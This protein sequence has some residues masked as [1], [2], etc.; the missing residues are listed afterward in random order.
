VVR[1]CA[2]HSGTDDKGGSYTEHWCASAV[3]IRQ[4]WILTAAHVVH[5]AEKGTITTDDDAKHTLIKIIV[6]KDYVAGNVGWHDIAL[7]RTEKPVALEF[8][9]KLYRASDELNKACTFAGWGLAGTF[10]SGGTLNDHKRRAGHNRIEGAADAVLFCS[11]TR[12]A[13]KFP[14]EFMITPGDSGGGMFIGNELAGINSFLMAADGKPNGTYTDETAFTRVSMYADW[15]ESQITQHELAMQARA[16][17]GT[18]I[19]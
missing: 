1:I 12:G 4:H 10:L 7:A 5:N 15:V 13:D 16:T 8:Y 18:H 6:H 9:P 14:L 3:V 17:E 11:P 2:Q 19:E